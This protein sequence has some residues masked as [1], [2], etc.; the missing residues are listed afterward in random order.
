MNILL[1]LCRLGSLV[2]AIWCAFTAASKVI[3]PLVFTIEDR[4][5]NVRLG[6]T[7]AEVVSILGDPDA[8]VPDELL[9]KSLFVQKRPAAEEPVFSGRPLAIV[10]IDTWY[11]QT[12]VIRVF[13]DVHGVAAR[14]TLNRY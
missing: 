13:Y 4:Y 1:A 12:G 6:V 7:R 14:K 3:R 9:C 11:E 2:C 10:G 8:P 5:E